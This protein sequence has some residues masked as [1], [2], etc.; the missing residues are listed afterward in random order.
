[1]TGRFGTGL[2]AAGALALLVGSG[3]TGAQEIEWPRESPPE[4]LPAREVSFP[5]YE[6]RT[7]DNGLQVVAV[8]HHEQP[9]VSLRLLVGAGAAKAPRG[10][11]GMGDLVAALLD[12]GTTSRS[13]QDIATEIDSIGGALSTGSG[14]DLTFV[15][16]VVM[17]DAFDFGLE[18]VSDVARNPAFA[19]EEI[20]RQKE[21]ALSSLQVSA[22]DPDYLASVVF[23]R[24]VYGFH[25][26]GVPNGG[27]R[28]TLL[29]IT[30]EDLAEYHRQYFVPN[31]AILAVVGDV[32]SDVAFSAVERVFGDWPRGELVQPSAE[33]PPPPT[34]RVVVVDMPDAVQTEVRVGHL[35]IPRR[36][37]DF[38]A[39]DLA[40]KILGGEGG[41]RLHRVLRTL[42]GLTYGA[43][44]EVEAQKEAGD[45]LA[46]TDTRTETTGEV[47]RLIV[48]EFVRL[49]N[50]PVGQRELADA[51]AYLA[52]NFPLSI[53]TPNQIAT[54][55][56]SNAFYELPISE[57]ETF[58]E[59]VQSVTQADIA[60]VTREYLQPDRLSIVLVGNAA[61]FVDQLRGV[62]FEEFEVI[63]AEDL[64][65]MSA[66]LRR[67][68][69][70][71]ARLVGPAVGR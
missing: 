1:V 36:H 8:A 41:N 15:S 56:L 54:Q 27:T 64:D 53:E 49:R 3:V 40:A 11:A 20:G 28:E 23:D 50:Q 9:I 39:F 34:R 29:S 43:S 7:L 19:P 18:F 46:Q 44:A 70:G 71:A 16:A 37:E 52:G 48:E 66:S 4:S 6:V 51:E 38:M 14:A 45:L 17:V 59:R 26:Y 25:P 60:R 65:L 13:A 47:L 5:P 67:A 61:A 35:G 31:N 42:R 33:E 62:G 30:A 22:N 12:Q 63:A 2:C 32:T 58:R 69:S 21:Q 10:K 68:G 24:L 57:I 55:V